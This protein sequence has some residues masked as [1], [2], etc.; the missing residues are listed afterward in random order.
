SINRDLLINGDIGWTLYPQLGFSSGEIELNNLDGFNRNHLAKI[1]NASIAIEVLPLFKGEIK[2]GELTLNGLVLNLITNKDGTS[3]LD[4]MFPKKAPVEAEVTKQEKDINDELKNQKNGFFAI[5]KA[6][7]AGVNITNSVI[8]V[9][10]LRAGSANKVNINHIH[11]GKFAL[12]KE[13]D[14]SVSTALSAAQMSA[15]IELQAKLIVAADFSSIQLNK[16]NLQTILTGTDIPNGKI[17]SSVQSNVFY[18]LNTAKAELNALLLEVDKI[19]LKG[20]VSVQTAAKTKVRFTLQGNEWDLKPY[21]PEDKKA[22]KKT[23]TSAKS[24]EVKAVSEQDPDL[25]FLNSLDIQGTLAIAGL[26]A[27]GLTLG[28]IDTVIEVSNGKARIKPLTVQLYQG[29]LTVNGW[30]DDAKGLNK[31]QLT[32]T[33]KNV[34]IRPLLTDA[35]QIDLLSGTTALNF[36]A[37]GKGLT[38]SKIKS[39][40]V[41]EG[42]FALL[43]GE[44][45]GVNIPQEIRALKA[46]LTGKPTPTE[47]NI[48][49]TDF[50]SL[51]GKFIIK[52]GVVDN[53]KLLMLS[54]VMRLDGAG[55]ADIL[56]ESLNYKLSV[57][58]LSKSDAETELY[59]L[60]GV[61]IPLLINGSFSDPK[62][63][64]DM[65]GA[66]KEELKM[67]T[68]Q[69]QEKAKSELKKQQE[70]LQDKSQQELKQEGKELEGK[71]KKELGKLFG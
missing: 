34:Q 42:D 51:T 23:E 9:Q 55:L 7:L 69:L 66:L 35:A 32:S 71:M 62:F 44:L 13:T 11:L 25:S 36:S 6:Q 28:K 40:L 22:A 67:K 29:L 3:N 39:G 43:D 5:N 1:E 19:Q 50:A 21:L 49:K 61:T 17:V 8:E 15:Q 47:A 31:Y 4:N 26:K 63:A 30:V 20:V 24:S 27:S 2:I 33:L 38:A 10:D 16:L 37:A 58:P 59:D 41:G 14:L 12:D 68:K 52:K 45:Y 65:D 18:N 60:K 54:P 70:K 64:L 46:K 53:N 56:H 57:T 48:K